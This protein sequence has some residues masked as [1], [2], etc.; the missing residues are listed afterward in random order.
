LNGGSRQ[1][2]RC[3][4]V[5]QFPTPD[6]ELIRQSIP[7]GQAEL[8]LTEVG[9]DLTRLGRFDM[10]WRLMPA[11]VDGVAH[12][13]LANALGTHPEVDW[14]HTVSAGIDHLA[15]LF[16]DRPNVILT[17]SAGVTAIPIAEFVVGCLLQHCKRV[18]ELAD[19]Q[20]ERRFVQL[21]LRE[22]GDMRVV[23][24]GLGAIGSEV[25][26]RLAPFGC[27][28]VGVR[29][30]PSRPTPPGVTQVFGSQ[31]LARSCQG[32]DALILVAPL[33]PDTERAVNAE[34]LAELAEGSVLVNVARGGLVD[35]AALLAAVS[36]GRPAAAYLDAFVEEPLPHGSP[37]WTAPGVHVS[38]HLSW[39]SS[40]LARR[41]S[42]LF[43]EQLRR[44][45]AGE[46]LR[47]RADPGAG[48]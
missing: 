24:L 20:R 11:E 3:L 5:G 16:A 22:L 6:V 21:T 19:L 34:V 48:Y 40:H 36:A 46:P 9:D 18:A 31:D 43:A 15:A 44:W 2:V 27:Q 29:R 33:T 37:L 14:V 42:E 25:A 17:H 39:S 32:A 4:A 10:I 13:Q 47:N 26:R 38:P 28:V 35:E 23:L 7:A 41:T 12:D 45:L 1:A 8:V 30:D